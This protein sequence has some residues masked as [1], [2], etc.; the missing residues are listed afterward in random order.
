MAFNIVKSLPSAGEIA[1]QYPVTDAHQ[2]PQRRQMLSNILAGLDKRLLV[3][4]GPCS[5]SP[6]D[7]VREYSDLLARFQEEVVGTI[8]FCL[9]TY[10]QKPRTTVGWTGPLNQPDPLLPPDI[11][12]GIHLCRQMMCDVGQQHPLA[13][14]MLFTHNGPYFDPVL[15]Y[16]AIGARSAEDAEHRYIAS[17]IDMPVGLK[18]PTSGDIEIGV[19]SVQAAQASHT[20]SYHQQEVRTSGNSDA[21]LILRG[22]KDSSNYGPKSI[23]RAHALMTDPKRA[24]RNPAIIVDA[25]HDNSQNGNGKDPTLQEHVMESVLLGILQQRPEYQHVRGFMM[26]SNILPGSQKIV[27][28]MNPYV[29]IT[30]PCMGWEETQRILR[31]LAARL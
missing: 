27:A 29:S 8:Q 12:R 25:S 26:E 31:N 6:F 5:A 13:D 21:H 14:E 17:G 3:I 20:F 16:T 10:I 1:Q 19:N 7:T 23:A 28:G 30:D 22:G 9:R 24:I 11:V 15:S 2:I 18:N 4:L